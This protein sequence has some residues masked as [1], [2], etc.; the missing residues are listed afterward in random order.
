[1]PEPL[2]HLHGYETEP[3]MAKIIID[4]SDAMAVCDSHKSSFVT[5]ILVLLP[6]S[7]VIT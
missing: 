4:N 7:N 3:E 2:K 1:M 5:L 6:N